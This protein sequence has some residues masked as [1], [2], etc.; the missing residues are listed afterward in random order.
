M[1]DYYKVTLVIP[2]SAFWPPNAAKVRLTNGHV[3]LVVGKGTVNVQTP[4][5]E[6][7]S[8]YEV[9]YIPSFF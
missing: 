5:G 1:D 2:L 4:S 7:K 9:P 3:H 8:I 6:I